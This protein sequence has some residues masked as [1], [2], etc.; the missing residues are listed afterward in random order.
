MKCQISSSVF[1][2]QYILTS[3]AV[4]V[5]VVA[6]QRRTG[7]EDKIKVICVCTSRRG[8]AALQGNFKMAEIL[9]GSDNFA[10]FR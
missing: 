6:W 8:G 9:Q 5:V 7:E 3:L 4:A 1:S 2:V 10:S